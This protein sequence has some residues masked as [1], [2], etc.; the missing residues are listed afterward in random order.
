MTKTITTLAVA[1]ALALSTTV[2]FAAAGP[3]TA[4]SE[5]RMEL[6]NEITRTLVC[7]AFITTNDAANTV[8]LLLD[9][10]STGRIQVR[11]INTG[12]MELRAYVER[13]LKNM[14]V[15]NTGPDTSV[16]LVIKF[17]VL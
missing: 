14:H 4:A 13:E 7:P 1:A 2:T 3:R 11:E 15:K 16:A 10:D 5:T 12:N 8:K 17:R 9:V 6:G